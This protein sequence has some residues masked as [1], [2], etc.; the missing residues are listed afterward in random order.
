RGLTRYLQ[1]RKGFSERFVRNHWANPS[2]SQTAGPS[3][4]NTTERQEDKRDSEFAASFKKLLPSQQFRDGLS[5]SE[6]RRLELLIKQTELYCY[7]ARKVPTTI[8]DKDWST[9]LNLRSVKDRVYKLEFIAVREWREEK[10]RLKTSG[11]EGFG[12]IM[13][14]EIE[15]FNAG[16]MGYGPLLYELLCNALRRRD[17]L[18]LI[19]GANV[20]SSLRLMDEHPVIVIDMQYVF[21]GQHEKERTM[22]NQL[23]ECINEN[24]CSTRPLP[25]I[26]SNVPDNENG[27]LYMEKDLDFWGSEFQH[28]MILPDVEKVSPRAAVIKATGKTNPKIVYI[29]QYAMKM[30]DGPLKADACEL[31]SFF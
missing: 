20:W 3:G 24:M 30:L 15:R 16:G 31:R 17:R 9:L 22:R 23:K 11:S 28:Q 6:K 1:N 29:S 8:S 10:D 2:S 18:N 5:E 21:D 25:V 26:L 4:T 12:A 14:Q 27:K 19:K 13:E 7:L